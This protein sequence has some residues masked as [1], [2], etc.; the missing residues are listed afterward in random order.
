MSNIARNALLSLAVSIVTASLV[1]GGKRIFGSAFFMAS[2]LIPGLLLGL[3]MAFLVKQRK[4][5]CFALSVLGMP[6]MLMFS[7]GL[8]K[9]GIAD[10]ALLPIIN[11]I[12]LYVF[13]QVSLG[14]SSR[15]ISLILIPMMGA[16][17]G[18]FVQQLP[19]FEMEIAFVVPIIAWQ[20]L[21]TWGVIVSQSNE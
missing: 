7:G 14:L 20:L 5:I 12:S 18:F 17:V 2:L 11:A 4:W 15:S 16:L 13:L 6:A 19:Y 9:I 21:A 8:Q 1:V 3:H 10:W